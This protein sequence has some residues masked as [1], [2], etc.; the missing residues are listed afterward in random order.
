M[1]EKIKGSRVIARDLVYLMVFE[2]REM[3]IEYRERDDLSLSDLLVL[4]GQGLPV[5]KTPHV[6]NWYPNNL[7][8]ATLGIP[9]KVV[10][11]TKGRLD[12]L[13]HPHRMVVGGRAYPLAHDN[14]LSSHNI[15]EIVPEDSP[16][17]FRIGESLSGAHMSA[18]KQ[19]IPQTIA[20]TVSQYFSAHQDQVVA[21]WEIATEIHPELW[22]RRTD[23][24]GN[25]HN[26]LSAR[27]WSQIE[28]VGINGFD[29]VR[30][31]WVSPNELNLLMDA[32]IDTLVTGSGEL[33]EL[34]G[35]SMIGYFRNLLP[36]LSELYDHVRSRTGWALPE[37][38]VFNL[39]P[40]ADMRFVVPS[41]GASRLDALVDA[42]LKARRFEDGVGARMRCAEDQSREIDLVRTQRRVLGAQLAE[43]IKTCSEPLYD[44]QAF[45]QF[46][47]YDLLVSGEEPYIN[48]W[49][50]NAPMSELKTAMRILLKA[51]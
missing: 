42:L 15:V 39:V 17:A 20:T 37:V 3:P 28:Q 36:L 4:L 33:Y 45:T 13:F 22:K 31:G 7:A 48:P 16:Y 5:F 51:A 23:E 2:E 38:M 12:T 34:S 41:S 46:T 35:P 9:S 29:D 18:L 44:T 26:G 21:I 14:R 19:A 6:G 49:A 30:A 47:Q 10:D 8:I 40:V 27:A 43:A 1:N 24:H 25:T 11:S 50:L 32:M